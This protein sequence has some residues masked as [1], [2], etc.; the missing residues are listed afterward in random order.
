MRMAGAV[1]ALDEAIEKPPAVGRVLRV[2]EDDE[3]ANDRRLTAMTPRSIAN[4][5]AAEDPLAPTE[6]L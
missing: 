5:H 2:T 3:D 4:F 1:E 6:L